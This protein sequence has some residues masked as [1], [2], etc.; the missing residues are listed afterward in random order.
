MSKFKP[1]ELHAFTVTWLFRLNRE[2]DFTWVRE[3]VVLGLL[4]NPPGCVS[5]LLFQ[6]RLRYVAGAAA[7]LPHKRPTVQQS[8]GHLLTPLAPIRAGGL[9]ECHL[10]PAVTGAC[11]P[12]GAQHPRR[13]RR[14][15]INQQRRRSESLRAPRRINKPAF[16]K[17]TPTRS[18][19]NEYLLWWKAESS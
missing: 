7:D 6:L 16:I 14:S 18:S 3:S 19:S 8:S 2:F 10:F 5:S 1:P 12:C 11:K 9:A 13:I 15:P 17:P 4:N